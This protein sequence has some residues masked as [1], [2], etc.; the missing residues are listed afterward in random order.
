MDIATD[1]TLVLNDGTIQSLATITQLLPLA[2]RLPEAGFLCPGAVISVLGEQL[3]SQMCVCRI[4]Y[5]HW[6][7]SRHW[8]PRGTHATWQRYPRPRAGLRVTPDS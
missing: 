3:C 5:G 8:D 7:D 2:L 4:L 6:E 1:S